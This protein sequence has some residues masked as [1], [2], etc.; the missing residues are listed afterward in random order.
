MVESIN[1]SSVDELQNKILKYLFANNTIEDTAVYARQLDVAHT[2]LD[3]SLKSLLVDDYLV[4]TVIER[5]TIELTDEGALY[6]TKGTPEYQYASA[7]ENGVVTD[8]SEVETRVG[9]EI[10]K[11]GFAKAMQRKWI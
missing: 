5:K 3:K 1:T 10:A 9:P 7:L 4:L 2:D 8:K 6:A 11:I